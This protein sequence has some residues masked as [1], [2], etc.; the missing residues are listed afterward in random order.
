[1]CTLQA[2]APSARSVAK[3]HASTFKVGGTLHVAANQVEGVYV[4]TF[5]VTVQY[6]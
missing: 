1:M 2:A 6:P 3:E 4:G 5:D